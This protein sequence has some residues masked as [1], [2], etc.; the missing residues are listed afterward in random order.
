MRRS[1][2][3]PSETFMDVP[4]PR[5]TPPWGRA[6]DV[7]IH[8]IGRNAE[9][10][11]DVTV[12]F[13]REPARAYRASVDVDQPDFRMASF[14]EPLFFGLS[15]YAVRRYANAGFY[16]AELGEILWAW[17]H[18]EPTP[19]L[20]VRLG[21]TGHGTRPTLLKVVRGLSWRFLYRLGLVKPKI[22]VHP[23]YRPGGSLDPRR[24]D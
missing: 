24:T 23:D 12:S 9:A 1:R 5:F 8:G 14:D 15:E 16:Q 10:G 18:G 4:I 6:L 3:G 22:W 20:P 17:E 19:R 13:G 7:V 2:P 21:T 11:L